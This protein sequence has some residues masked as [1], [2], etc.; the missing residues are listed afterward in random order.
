[1]GAA[2]APWKPAQQVSAARYL[3]PLFFG[4][5][6]GMIAWTV[7][8]DK[9]PKRAR[10]L[11]IFGLVWTVVP[12]HINR[13]GSVPIHCTIPH[14]TYTLSLDGRQNQPVR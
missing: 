5:L 2:A 6:G 10:N 14:W 9:D 11:L 12:H 4:I 7:N 13:T 8:K 3:V 1:M